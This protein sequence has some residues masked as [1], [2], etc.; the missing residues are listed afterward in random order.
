[1]KIFP[2]SS[3]DEIIDYVREL[4]REIEARE[5]ERGELDDVLA[6]LRSC[7]DKN[8]LHCKS[9]VTALFMRAKPVPVTLPQKYVDGFPWCK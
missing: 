3:R 4:E 7:R 2:Q 8:C 1:M 9:C 5:R 6:Q